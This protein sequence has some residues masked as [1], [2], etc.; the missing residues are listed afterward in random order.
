MLAVLCLLSLSLHDQDTHPHVFLS[1]KSAITDQASSLFPP[2]IFSSASTLL[3]YTFWRQAL[4]YSPGWLKTGY[5]D[6]VGL[7]LTEI[8]LLLPKCW[9][10]RPVPP[11]QTLTLSLS[12]SLACSW[13]LPSMQCAPV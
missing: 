12:P 8:C 2:L 6:Q 5:V 4:M 9:D 7:E 11:F 1:M 13:H 10:Q 3:L